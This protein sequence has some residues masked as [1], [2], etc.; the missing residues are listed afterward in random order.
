MVEADD[1]TGCAA[2]PNHRDDAV[3]VEQTGL[4]VTSVRSASGQSVRPCTQPEAHRL[5][6]KRATASSLWR[7]PPCRTPPCQ[8]TAFA[9]YFFCVLQVNAPEGAHKPPRAALITCHR[10]RRLACFLL[11]VLTDHSLPSPVSPP[12]PA[13]AAAGTLRDLSSRGLMGSGPH[14]LVRHCLRPAHSLRLKAVPSPCAFTTLTAKT[15]PLPCAC[16]ALRG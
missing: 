13:P 3:Q 14:S 5:A 16:A 2:V 7:T 4:S 11:R 1:A 12:A 10:R 9:L 6:L 8:D 15:L